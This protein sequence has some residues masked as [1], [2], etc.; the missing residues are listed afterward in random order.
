VLTTYPAWSVNLWIKLVPG[1][2]VGEVSVSSENG[3]KRTVIQ[4]ACQPGISL[5]PTGVGRLAVAWV[6]LSSRRR[7]ST[8]RSL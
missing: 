3:Q 4:L 1:D 8:S 5:T 2:S 7:S 6:M